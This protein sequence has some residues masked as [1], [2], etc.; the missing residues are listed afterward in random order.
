ML[1]RPS[2]TA[3]K[4]R[5]LFQ[6]YLLYIRE[7]VVRSPLFILHCFIT[8]MVLGKVGVLGAL[9]D[10]CYSY[11]VPAKPGFLVQIKPQGPEG[12][13][14]YDCMPYDRM[15]I[16]CIANDTYYYQFKID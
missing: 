14:P 6:P 1:S 11:D 15:Q 12:T 5:S 4:S 7:Y 2:K 13:L 9:S 10:H 3:I 16:H 8:F